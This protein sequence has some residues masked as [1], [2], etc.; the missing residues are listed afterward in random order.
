[1]KCGTEHRFSG[2]VMGTLNQ[3]AMCPNT[4][5]LKAYEIG[6]ESNLT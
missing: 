2:R 1:M 6:S 5:L 3:W 4:D